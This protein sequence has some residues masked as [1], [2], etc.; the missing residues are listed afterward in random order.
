MS[1]ASPLHCFAVA[2]KPSGHHA[3]PYCLLGHT[4]K[5]IAIKSPMQC[6]LA[7]AKDP[8]CRSF[9]LSGRMCQLNNA[10]ISQVDDDRH[11]MQPGDCTH[12][13]YK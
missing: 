7:C 1:T 8:N 2:N 3:Q 13:G 4:F 9:N 10:T 11:L 5:E 6:C 12:Y